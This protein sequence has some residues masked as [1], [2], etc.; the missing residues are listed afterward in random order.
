MPPTVFKG[1]VFV[2]FHVGGWSKYLQ[3]YQKLSLVFEGADPNARLLSMYEDITLSTA[4]WWD[5]PELRDKAPQDYFLDPSSRRYPYKPWEGEISCERLK[6]AMQLSSLH[7]HRQAS[8]LS[9]L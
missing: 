9:E 1:L 4:E 3:S 6:A 2:L 7:G 5:A 8:F